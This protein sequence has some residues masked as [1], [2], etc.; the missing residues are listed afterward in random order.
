L[1]EL[2][3]G[4]SVQGQADQSRRKTKKKKLKKKNQAVNPNNEQ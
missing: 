1:D 4:G 2:A 3:E